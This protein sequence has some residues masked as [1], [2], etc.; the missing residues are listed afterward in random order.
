MLG[1][2]LGG[3]HGRH[4]G[5][6][7]LVSDNFLNLNVVLA[8][9]RA[10]R[11]NATSNADLLWAMKGA[12]HNFG[13]VTSF[14]MNVFPRGP[15][16]WHYHNY[17][18]R[19]EKLEEVF[20]ALNDLH[21][22]GN[23]P[24]NMALNF[25]NFIMN[26]TIT[27]EEPII[28]WFFA[29]R[30][31]AEMAAPYLAPFNAIE[32]VYDESGDVPYPQISKAQQT[33]ADDPLCG[34]GLVRA[35][36]TSF[37]RVYNVT[38]TRQIFD[39]F[40]RRVVSNPA[41]AAGC[42]IVHEGYSTAAVDAQNPDDSAYPFRADHHLNL[43]NAVVP[44]GNSSLFQAAREW[45]KEVEDQW[46]AGEPGRTPSIYVNYANGLEPVEQIYGPEPW[47]LERLRGLKAK[48]DPYNRFRYFNPIIQRKG[49][50]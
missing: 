3:G 30:G 28:Y 24:V 15:D 4:E 14:E 16:T 31:T 1:A 49:Y 9:G 27:Q 44:P 36:S 37:L 25:G 11:V 42:N 45:A 21:D 12:G 23:T 32:A 47:R 35:L 8:D 17:I 40:K 26:T 41:L 5:L 46:N 38:T 22:N 34:D 13:I 2:G 43:F 29:Y 33:A 19:G 48:Y 7:G 10:I 39:G 18:W 50:Y 6:Y 20:T